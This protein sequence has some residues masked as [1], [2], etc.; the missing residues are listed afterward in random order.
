MRKFLFSIGF[1]RLILYLWGHFKRLN[2]NLHMSIFAKITGLITQTVDFKNDELEAAVENVLNTSGALAIASLEVDRL[3]GEE[4]ADY[5]DQAGALVDLG[6]TLGK[7]LGNL[8]PDESAKVKATLALIIKSDTPEKELALE[9]LFN[10]VVDT[11]AAI[12][13]LNTLADLDAVPPAE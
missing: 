7:A 9:T 5:T 2:K 11:N 13:A 1:R 8:N 3:A 4:N 10:T 6:Y 12:Q